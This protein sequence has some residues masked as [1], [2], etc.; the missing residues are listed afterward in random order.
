MT[1]PT[2]LWLTGS[3]LG[4]KPGAL[5]S[6]AHAGDTREPPQPQPI[7]GIKSVFVELNSSWLSG[8]EPNSSSFFGICVSA[9]D[10]PKPLPLAPVLMEAEPSA[11]VLM[12]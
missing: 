7:R 9:L 3:E 4:S 5:Y 8:I 6:R 11:K 2:E 1:P 12:Q 10:V